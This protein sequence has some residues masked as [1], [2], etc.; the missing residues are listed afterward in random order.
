MTDEP[1]GGAHGAAISGDGSTVAWTGGYAARQT[2]FLRGEVTDPS[3]DY[4]LWRRIADEPA[5]PTRRIT[6]VSDP[7]D[8]ACAQ[9]EAENPT[10]TTSFDQTSTGPCYGPLTD[11]ESLR[12]DISS[13]LPAL[14][15]DGYEVAFLTGAGPR[16]DISTGAGL[17]LYLTSMRPGLSRKEATTELTR[18]GTSHDPALAAPIESV[19]MSEDGNN[20]A[21][22]TVRTTFTLP[23]LHLVGQP[24]AVADTRELYAIDLAQATIERVTHSYEGGEINGD[25]QPG[26]TI[27]AG[28]GRIAFTS[29]AGDLFFGDANQRPDAFVATREDEPSTEGPSG[30]AEGGGT[31]LETIGGRH[32]P[33]LSVRVRSMRKGAVV[34]GVSVPAAGRLAAVARERS[35]PPGSGSKIAS[36]SARAPHRGTVSLVL[37]LGERYRANF[38]GGP[39]RARATVSFFPAGGSRPLRASVRVVFSH[40]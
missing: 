35:S 18:D 14:S 8:D 4:Y 27:S 32:G 34:L 10:M 25:V 39:I 36:G 29:F 11:Q 38:S 9:M 15:G 33:H 1:A 23:A 26:A 3:F 12:A 30:S 13:L 7:D 28:G 20:L 6:G 16:P 24:R 22:A 21:I 2:R 37:R 19:A 31:E 40:S 5:A 17:D